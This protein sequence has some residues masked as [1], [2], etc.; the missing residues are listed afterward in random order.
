MADYYVDQSGGDDSHDGLTPA[1]AWKTLSKVNGFSFSGSKRIDFTGEFRETLTVPADNLTFGAYGAGAAV[2]GSEII[3][4]S[5]TSV[6][7]GS[8]AYFK[9]DFESDSEGAN[10]ASFD[11]VT[12]TNGTNDATSA[13]AKNGSFGMRS[14][15]TATASNLW[16]EKDIGTPVVG[17]IFI[18]FWFRFGTSTND[19]DD[20]AQLLWTSSGG[21]NNAYLR[22]HVVSGVYTIYLG[23]RNDAGSYIETATQTLSINTWYWIQVELKGSTGAGANNGY[24]NL[25]ATTDETNLGTPVSVTS[26]DNDT[27]NRSTWDVFRLGGDA[28]SGGLTA[29]DFD[30]DD[31]YVH[32]ASMSGPPPSGVFSIAAAS[33]PWGVWDNNYSL[34][35]KTSLVTCQT[36]AGSFYYNAGTTTLYIHALDGSD[37]NSNG[38]TY[39]KGARELCVDFNGKNN[40]VLDG[41]DC[42]KSAGD[43][44]SLNGIKVTGA[45]N[46]VLNLEAYGS[47]RHSLTIYTGATGTLVDNVN[48]HD[49]PATSVIALFGVATDG[50]VVQ[51]ST[52]YQ[53]E[54]TDGSAVFRVHGTAA[55]NSIKNNTIYST[56]ALVN[57]VEM[58]D[59]DTDDNILFGNHIYGIA[60][61]LIRLEDADSSLLDYNWLDTTNIASYV[62]KMR[63]SVG[64]EVYNN[65]FYGTGTAEAV[66]QTNNSTGA[67]IKNNI[68]NT[69]KYIRVE[70]GSE[71]STVIDYN[72]YNGGSGNIFFWNGSAYTT[73]ADWKTASSQDAHSLNSDPLFT[74]PGSS[75]FTLQVTSPARLVGVDLG[76]TADITG[77]L[78]SPNPDMGAY[79]SIKI[80]NVALYMM[81]QGTGS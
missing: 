56:V 51:N 5:W 68:L 27:T 50:N 80:A 61:N 13:A 21:S 12:E 72:E 39:E 29:G 6:P 74:N 70:A 47:R 14:H 18:G 64:N 60:D 36:T 40:C 46:Q 48:M 10:P 76:L 54:P 59:A 23:V 71:T 69:G 37:P 15:I 66:A 3:S 78:V 58:Y 33:N 53:A 41:V 45:N 20:L 30:F 38:R 4:G 2:N 79:Q 42:V 7:G 17:P 73:F 11:S 52:F 62:V 8:A 31:F 81:Q 16:G 24:G 77:R 28:V 43:D 26:I 22:W 57:I 55:S 1:T 9:S 25:W 75:D 67:L 32:N 19:G 63:T 35:R 44:N 65:T 49:C 34:L